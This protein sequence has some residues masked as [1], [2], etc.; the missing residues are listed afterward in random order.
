[1]RSVLM[2]L[3]VLLPA[4]PALAERSYFSEKG[5][6]HD[7]AKEPE[8]IINNAGGS[9]T[10]TGACTK[11]TV[12]GSDNRIKAESVVRIL[13]NG[14]KNAIEVDAV[15]KAAVNGNDN[16]LTYKRGING[17]PKVTAIGANNKLNQVK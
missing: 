13:C 14:A 11:L 4:T 1:M 3:L 2:A 9:Y 7:C 12:N 5:V 15:D 17:K 8:I 16:T 6:T 10:F